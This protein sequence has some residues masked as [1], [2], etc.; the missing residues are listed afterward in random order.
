MHY[1]G[2]PP[3]PSAAQ[4]AVSLLPV[5][6]TQRY[7]DSGVAA[8]FWNAVDTDVSIRKQYLLPKGR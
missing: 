4:W 5:S 8:K 6:K 3:H 7:T 1:E 2:D